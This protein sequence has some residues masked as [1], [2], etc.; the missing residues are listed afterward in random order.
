M[1][2]LLDKGNIFQRQLDILP[3]SKSEGKKVTIIGAGAT[4]SWLALQLAKMG[5]E[6]LLVYDEDTIEQHNL[7][8][9]M[10]P[11]TLLGRNKASATGELVNFFTRSNIKTIPNYYKDDE[12]D[13]IVV[14]AVDSMA[15]RKEIYQ[16]CQN[17]NVELI[18]DPRCAAQLFRIYSIYPDLSMDREYYESELHDDSEAMQTRCTNRSIL[19]TVNVVVGLIGNQIKKHIMLEEVKRSIFFDLKEM[20]LIVE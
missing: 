3:P 15:A 10:F 9:Q 19:F 8:N 17:G 20:M 14:M 2:T 11:I 16:H 5:I 12:L 7:P 6:N 1:E 4:G 18:I 13:G